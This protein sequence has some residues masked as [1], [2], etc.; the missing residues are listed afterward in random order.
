MSAEAEK[1][2]DTKGTALVTGAGVR[3]GRAIAL[4]LGAAGYNV[5]VHYNH[6]EK[7]AREV[8][9]MI[10]SAGG[11]AATVAAD[12]M[13]EDATT[14]LIGRAE[15]ALGPITC[16]INNASV[17]DEDSPSTAT[18]ESWD[19][20]MQ[21]NLRAPFMLAQQ[22]A[23]QLPSGTPGNIVNI[24]DQRVWRLTP[25]FTT[26]TLSKSGLWTLTRTLAQALAPQIRV[27][28]I[29]PGPVIPSKRQ[30]DEA[31]RAQVD[32]L[33][34]KTHAGPEEIGRGVRFLLESGAVTGQMLA[35]DGGQHL[36]WET[37]DVAGI[38]E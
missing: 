8:A 21:V 27:N 14:S 18:R 10:E 5:A 20:H 23:A 19:R 6:S 7:P 33:L 25:R 31:F 11:K 16:L 3:V 12:L 28:A 2:S 32:A 30:D 34:L 24:I 22:M 36:A 15:E 4:E 1:A 37:P 17:F 9:A 26:Y 13:D 38:D 29:G 35:L